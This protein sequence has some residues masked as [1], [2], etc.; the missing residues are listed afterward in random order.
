MFVCFVCLQLL[1][2]KR[3]VVSSKKPAPPKRPTIY[4]LFLCQLKILVGNI[5]SSQVCTFLS[6]QFRFPWMYFFSTFSILPDVRFRKLTVSRAYDFETF[7]GGGW[8]RRADFFYKHE[9]IGKS[10]FLLNHGAQVRD[11]TQ[12][13]I[14]RVRPPPFTG[15]SCHNPPLCAPL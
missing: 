4:D 3:A 8:L 14:F 15:G 9:H 7:C 6:F 1:E 5:S 10:I 12:N 11:T 2:T 13:V